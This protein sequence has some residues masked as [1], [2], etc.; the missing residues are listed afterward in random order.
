MDA[1]RESR[2]LRDTLLDGTALPALT[3]AELCRRCLAV[4]DGTGVA[5]QLTGDGQTAVSEASD[6]A[7]A[8]A[9]DFQAT[10]GE[11][12]TIDALRLHRPVLVA[13]LD[14]D[15]RWPELA[16]LAAD[17]GIRAAVAVPLVVDSTQLG[18]L[19]I[20]RY[21]AQPIDGTALAH[22]VHVARV[23][24]GI[25]LSLLPPIPATAWPRA[26]PRAAAHQGLVHQAAGIVSVDEGC[27]VEEALVRLRAHAYAHDQLLIDVTGAS[28]TRSCGSG[29]R[30]PWTLVGLHPDRSGRHPGR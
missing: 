14:G 13:D 16:P 23:V 9:A 26:L 6:A 28:S 19:T 3:V 8:R 29:D 30:E 11:G 12:P 1:S 10:L 25:V 21:R 17:L 7:A 20:Y 24:A 27:S 2:R 15:E 18:A 4:V 22:I 5:V